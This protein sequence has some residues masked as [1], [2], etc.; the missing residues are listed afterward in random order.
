MLSPSGHQRPFW[1]APTYV[2][3]SMS[4]YQ[5]YQVLPASIYQPCHKSS[6][7]PVAGKAI[8]LSST[9][10]FYL[11]IYQNFLYFSISHIIFQN[12]IELP[13]VLSGL[14]LLAS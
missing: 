12:S 8:S 14:R 9:L 11:G 7:G 1:R 3:L 13:G 5:I 2:T 6:D 4:H 10:I